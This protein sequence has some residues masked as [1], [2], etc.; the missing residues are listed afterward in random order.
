MK[1]NTAYLGMTALDEILKAILVG[2]TAEEG[3]KFNRAFLA[4]F[5]QSGGVLEGKLAIGPGCREDAIRIWQEMH[6]K[7]MRFHDIIDSIKEHDFQEDSAVNR[8][9]KA[10]RIDSDSKEH[11]LIRAAM[12]R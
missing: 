12:E 2:I 1:M 11:I 9:A 5:D 7:E 3:L 8:I 6:S 4:L 10:L